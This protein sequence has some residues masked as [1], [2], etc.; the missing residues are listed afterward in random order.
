MKSLAPKG[1]LFRGTFVADVIVFDVP[2]PQMSEEMEEVLQNKSTSQRNRGTMGF[3]VPTIKEEIVEVVQFIPQDY[4]Q[5][6]I[7]EQNWKICVC[8]LDAVAGGSRTTAQSV[9]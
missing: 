1:S 2:M 8:T 7:A 9:N 4:M 5:E 3:F 6:R